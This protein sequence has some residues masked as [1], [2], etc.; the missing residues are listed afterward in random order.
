MVPFG[1]ETWHT[2]P[3]GGAVVEGSAEFLKTPNLPYRFIEGHML[4][5]PI[6]NV[7]YGMAENVELQV[8]GAEKVLAL[9]KNGRRRS[10]VGDFTLWT[11]WAALPEKNGRPAF[12]FRWGVKL[13]NTPDE[14]GLGTDET[15]VFGHVLVSRAF[16]ERWQAD[17]SAG[18]AILGNPQ[19]KRDQTDV[20]SYRASIRRTFG[21]RSVGAMEVKGTSGHGNAPPESVLKMSAAKI[22]GTRTYVFGA[23]SAG[24]TKHSPDWSVAAGA[25]IRLFR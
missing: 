20:L 5:A 13:P 18:V 11:K 1:A 24:L 4:R 7:R 22:F 15:D 3:R 21:K 17:L 23:L 9:P 10:A 12:G 14:T 19:K 6:W 8:E 2:L 25:G 16:G